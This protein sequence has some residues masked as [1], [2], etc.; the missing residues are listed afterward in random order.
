MR[1][2]RSESAKAF[3]AFLQYANLGPQQRSHTRVATQ[4][5]RSKRLIEGWSTQHQ[6]VARAAAWDRE[7]HEARQAAEQADIDATRQRH[8]KTAQLVSHTLEN[9]VCSF[10]ARVRD[11]ADLPIQQH[12]KLALQAAALLEHMQ[13]R[14]LA[15]RVGLTG[16][17]VEAPETTAVAGHEFTWGE[18]ECTCGHTHSSHVRDEERPG[19][20]CTAGGCS[21]GGFQEA[22]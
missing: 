21:C 18:G 19:L 11:L 5:K 22:A 20:R 9:V 4:L 17:A 16:G 12:A 8:K 1:Q 13:E 15:L 6:W 3:Q 14:E 10:A 2:L 7:Q